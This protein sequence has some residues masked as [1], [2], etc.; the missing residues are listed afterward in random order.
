M[1]DYSRDS[2]TITLPGWD[3]AEGAEDSIYISSG[4]NDTITLSDLTDCNTVIGG[5][6]ITGIS[7]P[8]SDG[9]SVS[10]G[11]TTT[12]TGFGPNWA[13]QTS[14]K[15]RLNGPDAD[16]EID[17]ESLLGML[18]AIE[19]RLNILKPDPSLEKEWEELKALGDQY[20]ALEKHIREKQATWDKLKAMPPPEID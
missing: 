2:I 9:T 20:R 18:R 3:D 12:G 16:I 4:S 10:T 17:G 13:S 8:W 1:S 14:A 11:W 15:I 5:A 19:G 6:S 7:V